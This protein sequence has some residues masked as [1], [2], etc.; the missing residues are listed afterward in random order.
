MSTPRSNPQP[1]APVAPIHGP[2]AY[3]LKAREITPSWVILYTATFALGLLC[4]AIRAAVVYPVLW[5][6]LKLLGEPTSP[7]NDLTLLA[8]YGPLVASVATLILPLGGWWWSS[9]QADAHHPDESKPYSRTQSRH[10]SRQ[11]PTC[12]HPGA[13]SLSIPTGRAARPTQTR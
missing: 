5:L 10:S 13:G 8:G 3:L 4:G 9:N 7:V 1:P 11:T 6:A 12:A 2:G